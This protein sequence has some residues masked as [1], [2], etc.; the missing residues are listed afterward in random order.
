MNSTKRERVLAQKAM[1]SLLLD[2]MLCEPLFQEICVTQ[3]TRMDGES[4]CWYLWGD[5]NQG[6]YQLKLQNVGQVICDGEIPENTCQEM[7]AEFVLQYLP[8]GEARPVTI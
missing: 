5:N 6:V 1:D 2:Y 4:P 3:I 7:E 8:F